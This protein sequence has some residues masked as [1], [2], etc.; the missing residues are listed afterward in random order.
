MIGISIA[1]GKR[2]VAEGKAPKVTRLSEKRI[3][4]RL[5]DIAQWQDG[6]QR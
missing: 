4:F 6:R 2:L 5:L 1:T 3:G